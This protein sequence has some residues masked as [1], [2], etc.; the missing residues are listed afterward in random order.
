VDLDRFWELV[1][2]AAVAGDV[3]CQAQAEQLTAM[4][5]QLARKEIVSF[6]RHFSQRL[7]EAYRWD[8][9]G[10]WPT[11]STAAAPTTACVLPLLAAGCWRRAGPAGRRR[12]AIR[13]R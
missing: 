11:S 5:E 13:T 10:G 3:D 2:A 12:L 6:E 1:E 9:C 7:A 4:L 8:L